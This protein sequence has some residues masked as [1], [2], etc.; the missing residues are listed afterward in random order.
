[1]AERPDSLRLTV[2]QARRIAVRAQLLDD[3]R[4]S[5]V[6]EVAERLAALQV[7]LT[8][9]VAPN[10]ELVLWSRLGNG[11]ST[12]E[13]AV[14]L[15][16]RRLVEIHGFLRPA[17][18]I[19]L[20]RAEMDAL[21]TPAWVEANHAARD[22]IVQVLRSE[23]AMAARDLPEIDFVKPWRSSGW[24]SGKNVPMMLER[25]EE[26]GQVAVSHRE[27]R[28]RVWD[29][30]E[31]V[32][33]DVPALP[34]DEALRVRAERRLAALGVARRSATRTPTEP[35]DVGEV[36]VEAVVEG[37][38]G[39]WRVDP[40]LADAVTG[41]VAGDAFAGRVA[42]ISPL[43]RLVFDRKRMDELF[44][45]DYTLEMYKPAATRRWGYFA[46]PVLSGDR[47]VGKV[48]A[49][50]DRS[51]GFL[52]VHAVH[53]DEPWPPEVDAAVTEELE[54][55]ARMVGLMIEFED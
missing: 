1:M 11:F 52:R 28:E 8:S 47:L 15:D 55:L 6:M 24:N 30:A 37:V 53:R 44:D 48:D 10:V 7:D 12:D 51:G 19:A 16:Q 20:Y 21:P 32:Y 35:N 29:L 54:S 39:R 45:F 40:E 3:P 9:Y 50:S 42:V 46:L 2:A 13:L 33:P 26:A 34:M 31:R 41:E 4:P 49:E 38:R 17:D 22:E 5:S 27:G 25:L 14:L 23:G 43:D 18:D 36:G